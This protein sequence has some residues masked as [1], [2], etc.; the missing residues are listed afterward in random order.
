MDKDEDFGL[1]HGQFLDEANLLPK[2]KVLQARI[3]RLSSSES[4]SVYR[5]IGTELLQSGQLQKS[6]PWLKRA[7]IVRPHDTDVHIVL[8][9]AFFKLEKEDDAFSFIKKELSEG[10]DLHQ[11]LI[12]TLEEKN[13]LQDLEAFSKEIVDMIEDPESIPYFYYYIAEALVRCNKYPEAL[14]NFQ[15]AFE[16]NTQMSQSQHEEYGLALY[17]EG[18]FEEALIQFE[19]I[20]TINPTDKAFFN[21]IAYLTYCAGKVEKALEGFEYIIENGLESTST[22]AN[23]ILVLYHLDQDE[24]VISTYRDL[25]Q[26]YVN[27]H[28]EDLRRRYN[29]VLRVTQA[30]L[31]RDNIDEKTKE[32]NAKKLKGINLLLSFFNSS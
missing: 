26:P 6:I 5:K 11:F 20:R 12:E 28:G 9:T 22:Y 17:H 29:E 21:N 10:T 7:Q 16:N 19:Q 30:I 14:A 2:R 25:L 24:E 4:D 15:K 13:K 18:L 32:F 1:Y 27:S 31:Q 3:L 23:F 8:A